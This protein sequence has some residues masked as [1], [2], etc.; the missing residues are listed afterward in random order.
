MNLAQLAKALLERE[1]NCIVQIDGEKDF[2]I[3]LV[4]PVFPSTLAL[5][6]NASLEKAIEEAIEEYDA[7]PE[8]DEAAGEEETEPEVQ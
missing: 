1:V 4:D 8:A 3:Q 5:G 6:I 7:I 2:V